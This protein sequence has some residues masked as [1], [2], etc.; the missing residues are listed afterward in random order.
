MNVIFNPEFS[1]KTRLLTLLVPNIHLFLENLEKFLKS[2]YSKKKHTQNKQQTLHL[3]KPVYYINGTHKQKMSK[4]RIVG[5]APCLLSRN[6]E[7]VMLFLCT[8]AN[9][10][11]MAALSWRTLV[12]STPILSSQIWKL[13]IYIIHSL[14][15]EIWH[16]LKWFIMIYEH[17]KVQIQTLKCTIISNMGSKIGHVISLH[18]CKC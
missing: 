6:W 17:M 11:P 5:Y 8:L 18:S 16:Q 2:M 3:K 4:R 14:Y 7:S 1:N 9:V 15:L 10:R 13:W 12:K